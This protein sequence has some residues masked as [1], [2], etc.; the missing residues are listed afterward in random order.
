MAAAADHK[1][2]SLRDE[3]AL[4]DVRIADLLE[5][6]KVRETDAL[7]RLVMQGVES[8]RKLVASESKRLAELGQVL[9]CEQVVALIR[10]LSDIIRRHVGDQATLRAISAEFRAVVEKE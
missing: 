9:T 5:S 6:M 3:V 2:L 10:R 7:W 4:C 8:R 1:L